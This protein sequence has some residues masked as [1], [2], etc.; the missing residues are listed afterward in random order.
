[1]DQRTVGRA[2]AVALTLAAAAGLAVGFKRHKG[3]DAR[4]AQGP[5]PW[6]CECGQAYRVSGEG[7]HRVYWLVDAPEADPVMGSTCVNCERPLPA[8]AEHP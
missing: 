2:I 1:M 5:Q 6:S 7:R 8:G 3:G 4:R